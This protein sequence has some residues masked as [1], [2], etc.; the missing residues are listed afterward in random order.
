M[1]HRHFSEADIEDALLH[2]YQS[3]PGNKGGIVVYDAVVGQRGIQVA[4]A[5]GSDPPRIIS[6]MQRRI[7]SG[8]LP[9]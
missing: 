5:E 1:A 4:V 3:G 6:V 7:P 8:L 9:G 2:A